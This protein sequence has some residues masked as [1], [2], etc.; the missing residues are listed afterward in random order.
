MEIVSQEP[1]K[2]RKMSGIL[3]LKFSFCF[4]ILMTMAK[5]IPLK[6]MKICFMMMAKAKRNGKDS[7]RKNNNIYGEIVEKMRVFKC[8]FYS[9]LSRLS[10]VFLSVFFHFMTQ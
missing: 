3:W 2:M 7:K 4:F 6:Y 9:F 5:G 1:K 8:K 10:A